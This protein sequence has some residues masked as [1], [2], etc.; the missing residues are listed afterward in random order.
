MPPGLRMRFLKDFNVDKCPVS[1]KFVATDLPTTVA[2]MRSCQ[3]LMLKPFFQKYSK[4]FT[5]ALFRTPFILNPLTLLGTW[6]TW[7]YD[8]LPSNIT[9]TWNRWRS[10]RMTED[11]QRTWKFTNTLRGART[12]G[13]MPFKIALLFFESKWSTRRSFGLFK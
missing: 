6:C 4:I 9:C 1:H 13:N 12:V 3:T 10:W 2:Q 8:D 7:S 11:G 5:S